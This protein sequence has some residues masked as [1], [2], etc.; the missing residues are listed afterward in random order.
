MEYEGAV[1][2]P[3]SEAR[4]LIVQ[5][6]IGCAHNTCTFC[7]MYIDKQFRIRALDDIL[8]DLESEARQSYAPFVERVFLADGDAL[9]MRTEQLLAILSAVY[10]LFPHIARVSLY[11]TAGDVLRKSDE[12]LRQLRAAG[13]ELIYLGA[14]SG[15]DEILR[16]VRKDTTSREMVAAAKRLHDSG[17]QCSVTLISGLGGKEKITAHAR[18]SA[19][20]ISCMRPLYVSFLT[21]QLAPGTPLYEDVMAGRFHRITTEDSVREMEE[22]L[23]HVDAPGSIFRMNHASNCFTLAG[24]LNKDIPALLRVLQEVKSGERFSRRMG[25]REIL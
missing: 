25:A 12:E 19:E 23:S 14:E 24:T 22:F 5:V 3:P 9:V 6:T 20:L 18:A 11:G 10:R 21:L 16:S 15:D 1:Y 2:R 4:S 8:A 7:N 13:L 17:M